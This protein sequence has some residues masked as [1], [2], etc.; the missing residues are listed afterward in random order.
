MKINSYKNKKGE[1]LY[2]FRIF[3]GYDPVTGKKYETKNMRPKD[4]DSRQEPKLKTPQVNYKLNLT[5]ENSTRTAMVL[6][7]FKNSLIYGLNLIKTR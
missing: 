6:K 4:R 2:G 1:T 3:L 5:K 7:L